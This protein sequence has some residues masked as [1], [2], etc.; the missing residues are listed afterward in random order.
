MPTRTPLCVLAMLVIVAGSLTGCGKEQASEMK[1]QVFLGKWVQD[2]SGKVKSSSGITLAAGE[3]AELCHLELN[4]DGT[5]R[6]EVCDGEGKP[7]SPP[8]YAEGTWEAKG[9]RIYFHCST[10]E[11]DK[12]HEYWDPDV[13]IAIG[14]KARGQDEDYLSIRNANSLKTRYLRPS[15]EAGAE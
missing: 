14:L 3:A 12:A 7:I 15:P 10:R 2:A 5:Y 1:N 11:L 8:Q 13:S 6:F 9:N 4:A